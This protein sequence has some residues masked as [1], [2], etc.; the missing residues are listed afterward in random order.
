VTRIGPAD[1][2]RPAW[3]GYVLWVTAGALCSLSV[4][5]LLS[6]G[7]FIAP[8][9]VLATAVAARRRPGM[10]NALG[11]VSGV[12]AVPLYVGFIHLGS[13]AHCP[14]ISSATSCEEFVAWPWLVVG[15]ALVL[16]GLVGFAEKRRRSTGVIAAA[17]T[18]GSAD[19]SSLQGGPGPRRGA[20]RES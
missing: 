18:G 6:I 4:V 20:D 2:A 3:S 12:G 9:A 8:V 10:K 11:L 7:P 1:N 13:V 5:A 17:R 14:R 19:R 15:V 16:A